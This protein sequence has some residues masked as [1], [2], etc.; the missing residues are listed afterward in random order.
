MSVKLTSTI[1][2]FR[3]YFEIKKSRNN[4][5]NNLFWNK[6]IYEFTFERTRCERYCQ[7]RKWNL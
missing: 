5:Q 2:Y 3:N 4:F 1:A 7:I 6:R